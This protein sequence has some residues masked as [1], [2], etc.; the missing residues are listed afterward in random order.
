[1]RLLSSLVL[2]AYCHE[3]IFDPS[4][5]ELDE[6]H[7]FIGDALL[8]EDIWLSPCQADNYRRQGF[9]L[10]DEVTLSGVGLDPSC[11]LVDQETPEALQARFFLVL[12]IF[13]RFSPL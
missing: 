1:M 13:V 5:T 8:G 12:V 4:I 3:G 9:N 2:S 6:D 7:P 11:G 10:T